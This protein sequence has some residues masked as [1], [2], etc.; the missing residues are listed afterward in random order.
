MPDFVRARSDEQREERLKEIKD[1]T[2]KMILETSY[3]EISLATIASSL[4]W[5]RATLYK[6][7]STKEEIILEI[8]ADKHIKQSNEIITA[9]PIGSNFDHETISS[10]WAGI[11]NSNKDYLTYYSL[12]QVILETNVSLEKLVKFKKI[13]YRYNGMVIE[14]FAEY[15][16]CTPD[17]FAKV[18]S[19]VFFHALGLNGVC[20]V[21][22]I[23]KE[24]SKLAGFKDIPVD[25]IESMKKFILMCIHEYIS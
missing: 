6:Y 12:L 5:S 25:F 23:A 9:C 17:T 19:S 8:L 16:N 2:E 21:N 10:I 14:H 15:L 1:I 18:Y 11:I 7:V 13:F 24:A 3:H 20:T 4:G 22:P